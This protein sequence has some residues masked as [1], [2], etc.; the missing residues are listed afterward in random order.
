MFLHSVG[1]DK[2]F[3][4]VTLTGS[5]FIFGRE[6]GTTPAVERAYLFAVDLLEATR[7]RH[8]E[9]NNETFKGQMAGPVVNKSY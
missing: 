9:E 5:V 4:K 8:L 6:W 1:I 3:E 7:K 2:H